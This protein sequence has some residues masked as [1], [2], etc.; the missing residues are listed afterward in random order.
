[1]VESLPPS[2]MSKFYAATSEGLMS[3]KAYLQRGARKVVKA[4]ETFEDAMAECLGEFRR[5]KKI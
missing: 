5:M 4:S 3:K 2:T 1:M